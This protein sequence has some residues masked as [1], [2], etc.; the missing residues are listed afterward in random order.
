M[1][2]LSVIHDDRRREIDL[3]LQLGKWGLKTPPQEN[4]RRIRAPR[5]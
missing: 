3:L 5:T 4:V 1:E 2:T